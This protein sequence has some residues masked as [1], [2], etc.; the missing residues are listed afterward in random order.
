MPLGR[1]IRCFLV[2]V[3]FAAAATAQTAESADALS[4]LNNAFRAAYV[5]ARGRALATSDPI[6]IANGNQF[7]LLR[8]GRRV[9]EKL[10]LPIYDPVK[11]IAH[12]PLAIYVTL[13]PGDGAVEEERLKSLAHL[14]ELIPPAEAALDGLNLPE[15]TV[16][17]Q[18]RIIAACLAFLDGVAEKHAVARSALVAFTREMAPLV[19]ENVGEASRAQLDATHA[20][21][22]RWRRDMS[23]EEWSQL[24][25]VIT[26]PHMAREGLVTQ[27]YFFRLLNEPGE[28]GRVVFAEAVWQE[29]EV[30]NLLGVHLLD[31]GI[32][33]AFFGDSTRMHRDLLG[34]AATQYLPELKWN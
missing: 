19:L 30:L 17:R 23:A 27:Q 12:I 10:G 22:S 33:D 14:R 7:V 34:D 28:G 8:K 3:L 18:K 11:T 1:R 5:D 26:G 6:L 9:E 2:P 29:A 20:L 31:G 13:T 32:G 25:V 24:H 15:A 16:S 21:V 4:E